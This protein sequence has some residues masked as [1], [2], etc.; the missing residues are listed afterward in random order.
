[1][2]TK[3]IIISIFILLPSFLFSWRISPGRLILDSQK[4]TAFLTLIG[5][6]KDETQP[7]SISICSREIDINGKEKSEKLYDKFYVIPSS[8]MLKANERKMVRIVWKGPKNIKDEVSYRLH[9]QGVPITAPMENFKKKGL[10][11]NLCSLIKF[12]I[13][14]YVRNKSINLREKLQYISC[15]SVCENDEK[16]LLLKLENK[17][18]KHKYIKNISLNYLE[19]DKKKKSINIEKKDIKGSNLVLAKHERIIKVKWPENLPPT[20]ENI[21]CEF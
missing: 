8:L 20:A 21:T 15:E 1:M 4:G 12:S 2:Q 5:G 19:K 18:N 16:F 11:A 17:G 14:I 6:E 7:I 13:P 3:N 9:A 10:R